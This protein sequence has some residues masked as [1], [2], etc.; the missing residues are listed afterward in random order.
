MND[1]NAN[2]DITKVH[3][4]DQN[5]NIDITKVHWSDENANIDITK[6]HLSDEN[7]N[8]DITKVHRSDQNAN[9]DITKVHRSD[10][11]ANIDITKVHWSVEYYLRCNSLT[12]ICINLF[13]RLMSCISE[14]MHARLTYTRHLFS[15]VVTSFIWLLFPYWLVFPN[16]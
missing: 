2:I 3:W 7:A 4:S 9:I 15:Y 11:N 12:V 6:V 13:G 1:Q 5:A 8:I 10:Q 14:R 16:V